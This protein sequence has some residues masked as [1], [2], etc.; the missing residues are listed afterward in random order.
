[1]PFT[2]LTVRSHGDAYISLYLEAPAVFTFDPAEVIA[3]G[4]AAG[5][6][7]WLHFISPPGGS[8]FGELSVRPTDLYIKSDSGSQT[9]Q[10]VVETPNPQVVVALAL[11]Q[12]T[13]DLTTTHDSR[14]IVSSGQSVTLNV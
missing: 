10:A 12:G 1:M 6:N 7:S 5:R 8:G 3:P 9:L 11:D 13:V 2:V 14:N 4:E